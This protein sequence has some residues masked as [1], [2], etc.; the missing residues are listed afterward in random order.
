MSFKSKVVLFG[1]SDFSEADQ[2]IVN[3]NYDLFLNGMPCMFTY[4]YNPNK[5]DEQ[6]AVIDDLYY[7]SEYNAKTQE[8]TQE[9][10]TISFSLE[11][12]KR[13][14]ATLD[15]TGMNHKVDYD[16]PTDITDQIAEAKRNVQ[17]GIALING[18]HSNTTPSPA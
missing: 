14:M 12:G 1:F 17:K 16:F 11:E 7:I 18:D 10:V 2:Q 5:P 15:H 9:H 13:L 3:K 4:H 6:Y 8:T